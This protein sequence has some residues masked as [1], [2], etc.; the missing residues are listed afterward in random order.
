M[1]FTFAHPAIILPF[2]RLPSKWFSWT[3]LII[4]A[5][6]PD[7]ECFI[8][9]RVLSVYGHTIG[10][11]FCF[12]LPLAIVIAFLFHGIV[13]SP[14]FNDLPDPLW[15]RL[16]SFDQFNW[17]RYF[18]R[19]W[20]VVIV[21]ILIGAVSH[22]LWD[23]FTH[24]TGYF[25]QAFLSLDKEMSVFGLSVPVFKVLQH[26]SSVLGGS[27]VLI[28]LMILPVHAQPGKRASRGYWPMVITIA[29][30]ITVLSADRGHLA[31]G[32]VIVSAISGTMVA[33]VVAGM[34]IGRSARDGSDWATETRST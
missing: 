4:G 5:M 16:S 32:N 28:T 17:P 23:A 19:N 9:F 30:A 18:S 8:R 12:D 11:L 14:L 6:V 10:G 27:A 29:A 1:P 26:T 13:R 15:R 33:L 20:H 22:L 24:S 7:F 34:L 3:G 2:G 31:I 25:V 21:S